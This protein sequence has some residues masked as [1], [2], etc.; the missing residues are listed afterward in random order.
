MSGGARDFSEDFMVEEA[1][2]ECCSG[3]SERPPALQRPPPPLPC[4]GRRLRR[5]ARRRP[6]ALPCIQALLPP[7]PHAAEGRRRAPGG[8]PP[9]APPPT[10]ERETDPHRLAQRQKQVGC[11]ATLPRCARACA[12][13]C[14]TAG[15]IAFECP[16]N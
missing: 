10:A 8:L 14:D 5:L 16:H 12:L 6:S 7:Q 2:R 4:L 15:W 13:L 11:L 9:G 1:A 3:V